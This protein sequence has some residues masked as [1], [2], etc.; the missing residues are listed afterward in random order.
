MGLAT[1]TRKHTQRGLHYSDTWT[2]IPRFT[3]KNSTGEES[4]SKF[5]K[6][7]TV[8]AVILHRTLCPTITEFFVGQNTRSAFRTI[9]FGRAVKKL[10]SA[11]KRDGR[12]GNQKQTYFFFRPKDKC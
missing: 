5:S 2:K 7:E 4:E 10:R 6:N 8:L 12:S 3:V 11:L 1:L 9:F